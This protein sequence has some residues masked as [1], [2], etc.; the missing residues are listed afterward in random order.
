MIMA[1]ND[2]RRSL[3]T[4]LVTRLRS[5]WLAL[6][7]RTEAMTGAS[8]VPAAGRAI[9]EPQALLI[10]QLIDGLP[11]AAIVLDREGRVIAFNEMAISIASALRRGEPALIALRMPELVD[12]IRRAT[13][14]HEPQRVEF[15]E[16][17]PLDLGHKTRRE[18]D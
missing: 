14:R 10:E 13:R 16:R 4:P 1:I 6:L 5:A 17:V 3:P 2:E 11:E 8:N 9:A 12:A 15:F 7:G 18:C